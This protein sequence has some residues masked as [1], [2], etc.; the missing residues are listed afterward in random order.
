MSAVRNLNAL[1]M[2]LMKNKNDDDN[3]SPIIKLKNNNTYT[4]IA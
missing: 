2:S 4:N 1:N 3:N